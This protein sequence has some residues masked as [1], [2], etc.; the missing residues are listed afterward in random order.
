MENSAA[1][2][3]AMKGADVISPQAQTTF[4]FAN[5]VMTGDCRYVHEVH[6]RHRRMLGRETRGEQ[7]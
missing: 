4:V 2:L 1:G 5:D 3:K 6:A 7:L